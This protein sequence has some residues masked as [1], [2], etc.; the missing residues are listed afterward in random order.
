MRVS[1]EKAAENRERILDEAARLFR[2]R[3]LS[4]VGVDGLAE[5]AGLTYGSL[6]IGHAI[7]SFGAQFRTATTIDAYVAQYLS[8]EHRDNPG[9]GCTAAAM[10][11]EMPR[12]SQEVRHVFTEASKRSMARLSALLPERGDHSREDEALA[13]L[14]TLAGAMMLARAVDDPDYSDRILSACRSRLTGKF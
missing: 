10:G 9:N 8:P 3:G 14:A 13:M 1:K 2:E 6:Y 11:C 4:G 12:Q 7:S 5:A